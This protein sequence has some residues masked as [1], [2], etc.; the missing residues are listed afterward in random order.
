MSDVTPPSSRWFEI[1]QRLQD[2]IPRQSGSFGRYECEPG[3]S[4]MPRFTDYGFWFVISGSGTVA[5]NDAAPVPLAAG[6]L[7]VSRPGESGT[8]QQDPDDRLTVLSCHFT[9]MDL[10]R[11]EPTELSPD[12][13]PARV[14]R[15]RKVAVVTELLGRVVRRARDTSPLSSYAISGLLMELLAEVYHNDAVC[16]GVSLGMDVRLQHAI[17]IILESPAQRVTIDELSEAVGMQ[18]RQLSGLFTRELGTT[19][20]RFVV[21]ARLERASVLLRTAPM[22]IGQI[23]TALGYVDQ[24]LF[25][26][27]FRAKFGEPPIA[28]RDSVHRSDVW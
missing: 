15:V 3:W 18:P 2:T 16:N 27:Q 5:L 8:F 25:S 28:Y 19:F 6:T 22:S 11:N 23:A 9:F 7:V 13:L 24:F 26:R 20:R 10:D 14:Q 4:W 1:S 21:E 17:E 12:L